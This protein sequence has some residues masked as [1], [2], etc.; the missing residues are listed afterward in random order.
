ME[1]NTAEI[2]SILLICSGVI[3]V[4]FSIAKYCVSRDTDTF[5]ILKTIRNPQSST[6]TAGV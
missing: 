5:R 1:T 4:I 3:P 6:R 2:R